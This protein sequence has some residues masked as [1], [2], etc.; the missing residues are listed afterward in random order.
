LSA[1]SGD[2]IAVDFLAAP[3]S[4][5]EQY[6]LDDRVTRVVA[7]ALMS[8][9][10]AILLLSAGLSTCAVFAISRKRRMHSV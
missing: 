7:A 9:S 5:S 6:V 2:L 1:S 8:S 3:G 4:V 10:A